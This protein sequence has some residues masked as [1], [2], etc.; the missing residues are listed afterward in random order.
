MRRALVSLLAAALLA[1]PACAGSDPA[2]ASADPNAMGPSGPLAGPGV[3]GPTSDSGTTTA[4]PE[5]PS[6]DAWIPR[7]PGALADDLET[8]RGERRQAIERWIAADGPSIWP[9][10]EDVQLLTLYEQRIYRILAAN[11]RLSEQVLGRLD[12][13]IA[14][15]ARANVRAGGALYDH[16]HPVKTLPDFRTRSPEPA[17]TLLV[18]F[19]KGERR[20]GVHWELLAAVMLIETRMGRIASNS[21]AGAQGPMQFIPSTWAA[22]GLGGD[23]RD[24]HDAVLGAAN[25]LSA[26]GAPGDDRQALFHY[27]PVPAYVTAV[28]RYAKAMERDRDLFYAYYNWQ[29]FVRTTRGDVRLTGP[30]L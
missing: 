20:F 9:P 8:T 18:Y 7:R 10:P 6:P 30:G 28:T 11:D 17:D 15:E 26:N 24:P 29:V 22:Y 14:G 12:M 3:T 16:F 19:E 23:V 2:P 25:Y 13:A 4:D 27:N 5:L 1:A 21:S